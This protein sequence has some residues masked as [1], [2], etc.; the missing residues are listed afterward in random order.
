MRLDDAQIAVNAEA[1]TAPGSLTVGIASNGFAELTE[2]IVAAFRRAHPGVRVFLRDVTEDAG[3]QPGARRAH[4][5][6]VR[7][8]GELSS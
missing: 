6:R 4:A 5:A 1:R 3:D 2:P 7:G 8:L